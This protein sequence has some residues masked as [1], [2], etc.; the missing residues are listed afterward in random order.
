MKRS[1]FTIFLLFAATTTYA[2]DKLTIIK[3]GPIGEIAS[4]AEANEIRVVFNEPMVVV[5]KIPK[6]VAA[7]FFHITPAVKG[8]FRWSGTTTLIFTPD[9]KM[10][11]PFATQFDVTIDPTAKSVTG[12][13][14]D[15]EYK[16][17]F[18][19]PTIRLLS[20]N[21]YHKGGRF[22]A[23]VVIAL[24][25]NQPVD[26]AAVGPHLQLRTKEH[27]FQE[28]AVPLQ[29]TEAFNTKVAAARTAASSDGVV[30]SSIFPPEWDRKRF[31]ASPDL[32]V[33]ETNVPVPPGTWLQVYLDSE[34][35]KSAQQVKSGRSQSFTV[36]LPQPFFVHAI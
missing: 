25:F 20:T 31:P 7:P 16:F 35:A 1:A 17:S 26:A 28:P 34:L 29:P 5:G 36:Q 24:R 27:P 3:A 12:K 14:L 4:L 11:L 2:A 6:V 30:I 9:P 33:V 19:T 23:P 13:A 32:V 22:D 10:P 21:W 18:V 15:R 8:T